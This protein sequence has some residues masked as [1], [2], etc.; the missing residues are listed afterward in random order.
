MVIR[1]TNAKQRGKAWR[2]S[3]RRRVKP[4]KKQR[5]APGGPVALQCPY[6]CPYITTDARCRLRTDPILHWQE[7]R[8]CS[9]YEW[10]LNEKA[11]DATA[12]SLRK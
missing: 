8:R 1:K 3:E 11:G 4:L 2:G 10:W 5:F 7:T 9:F 12:G 6:D